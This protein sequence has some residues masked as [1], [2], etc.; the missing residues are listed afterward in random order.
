M[1]RKSE[2]APVHVPE[3]GMAC[4]GS[5]VTATRTSFWPPTSATCPGAPSPGWDLRAQYLRNYLTNLDV[6]TKPRSSTGLPHISS[7]RRARRRAAPMPNATT[8]GSDEAQIAALLD[9]FAAALRAKDARALIEFYSRD[10]VAYDL[11]PP[12]SIPSAAMRD[13]AYIQQW[14][15]TWSGPIVSGAR[16]PEKVVGWH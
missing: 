13:P 11:A 7:A 4:A 15:D 9:G 5:R 8:R 2:G 12:L 1:P 10:V 14:F 16:D 3:T 6:R